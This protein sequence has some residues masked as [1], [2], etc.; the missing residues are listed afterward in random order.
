MT[1][2]MNLSRV[3]VG[4]CLLREDRIHSL[5]A[6]RRALISIDDPPR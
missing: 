6:A 2:L 4:D 5:P 3:I 1:A